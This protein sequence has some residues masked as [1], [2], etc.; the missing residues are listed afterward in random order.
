MA[1]QLLPPLDGSLTLVPGCLDFHAR[2]SPERPWVVFPSVEDPSKTSS[3]S[4]AEF[5]KATH[6]IAH[7]ARP[8]RHGKEGSVV[9]LL[10]HCDSIL[11]VALIQGLIRAGIVP[12]PISPR[13]STEAI[14]NL[15]EK[16]SSV[17]LITHGPLKTL[18]AAAQAQ[19]AS[20]G[21]HVEVEDLYSIYDIFPTLKLGGEADAP[22]EDPYPER[23]TAF[24]PDEPV[25]VLHS[26]G[27][28][29]LPKA[30]YQTQKIVL[31]WAQSDF[32]RENRKRALRWASGGMPTFHTMGLLLQ[33]I[34]PLA[35]GQPA[36][37]FT[38]QEPLAPVI[39]TADKVLNLC[40]V[41]NCNAMPSVPAFIDAWSQ[42]EESLKYLAT[43]VTTGFGG[44]PLSSTSGERLVKAGITLQSVYGSTEAGVVSGFFD[45][46]EFCGENSST[47]K[48]KD[49]WSWL[50]FSSS[51]KPRW[52]P[53]GDGSFE[54]QFLTCETHQPAVENLPDVKGYATRD[55]YEPHPT[56]KN[57]WRVVGRQDDVIVLGTGE[58][59]VPIQQEGHM[60]SNAIIA[61]AVMFGRGKMQ[62]GVI[63]EPYAQHAAAVFPDNDE[64]IAEF[65]NKVWPIIAEANALAPTF[66][67]V[68]KEMILI[69]DPSKPLPRA[70]KGTIMRKA[71]LTLYANEI[72]M[73][74]Q[75]VE[76]G[77]GAKDARGP[78]SWS[79]NN[80][81]TWLLDQAA[82][83]VDGVAS[84]FSRDLF[85]QGF[86]SLSA[87]FL[88]NRIITALR[89][90]S[91]KSLQQ[92][93]S[94]VSQN[95]VFDNPTIARL[96]A[97]VLALHSGAAIE[98]SR[99][100]RIVELIEKYTADLPN[101]KTLQGR[102]VLL[103]G[104]TGNIGAHILASLLS[105][106]HVAKVYTLDRPLTGATPQQRLH[107]A[108]EQRGLSLR[109][110][111]ESRVTALA[112][113]LNARRFGLDDLVYNEIKAS[114]THVVLNGWKVDFNRSLGSFETQI[115]GTRNVL[116]FCASLPQ[117][118]TTMFTSSISVASKWDVTTG[119]VPE[120]L[121]T[122]P[123][124]ASATGYSSSKYVTEQ[125]LAKASDKGLS[126]VSLRVGQVSGSASTG[127]WNVT[128]WV[129]ILVKSS[130]CLG[131]LPSLPGTISWIP[132]D[133]VADIVRDLV[134]SEQRVSQVVNVLHPRPVLW[135]HVFRLINDA[136]DARL[137]IVPYAQWLE[138][139]ESAN[140]NPTPK[141]LEDVPA[142]KLMDFFRGFQASERPESAV[143]AGGF[144]LFETFKLQ[145][146]SDTAKSLA[147][148]GIGHARAWVAYW[149]EQ[150]LFGSNGKNTGE[151]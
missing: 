7:R 5:A 43:L 38:P 65:R 77:A 126:T 17:R 11:Y 22:V 97:A 101:P 40:R 58:K 15:I 60:I 102:V 72:E 24:S 109:L 39:P 4:F 55:L 137:P 26:S 57:L 48:T 27:S 145:S 149:K 13:N 75:T 134:L 85:E 95:F 45:S 74:Y 133:A 119:P 116:N 66:A 147:P 132:V 25:I 86:D 6:R 112:G 81:R 35:T 46:V 92:A 118:V 113:D 30:I 73:L 56:K 37:L 63:I 16:T 44:G 14:V 32:C 31:Q 111:T 123:E 151:M 78:T 51:V 21:Q 52:M 124:V 148:V 146:Q 143:E 140:Q 29:G 110:L 106:E 131:A 71:A 100:E 93:A 150:G 34:E 2:H 10:V 91:D 104:S 33:I 120:E 64:S 19:L 141:V 136:L 23:E 69:T 115:S 99:T 82:A 79:E 125:L 70:G 98:K 135:D 61:G 144:P 80:I 12:M 114:L 87:T 62:P 96:A 139:L 128:D 41:T 76:E 129:P 138:K 42:S 130:L 1:S 89:A 59:I 18:A 117:S 50:S 36:A 49:E 3:I 94:K 105:D 108:F 8:G 107:A 142:L 47:G 9:G 83:L 90:A 121:I 20:K 103:T 127:T 122:D 68:F 28:T 84:D 54:L 67:K 53:Q 88:R